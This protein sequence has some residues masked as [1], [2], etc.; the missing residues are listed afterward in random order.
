MHIQAIFALLDSLARWTS[1]GLM[2]KSRSDKTATDKRPD[3]H[4]IPSTTLLSALLEE[5]RRGQGTKNGDVESRGKAPASR[6]KAGHNMDY[7]QL[8]Q[9]VQSLV[10]GIPLKLLTFAA[11]R[12]KAYAR[13]LRYFELYARSKVINIVIRSRLA[14]NGPLM[15]R[16]MQ[17]YQDCTT[18]LIT[19]PILDSSELDLVMTIYSELEDPDAIQ[20]VQ[21][22]RQYGDHYLSPWHR[23]I[24]LEQTDDWL[25]ALLEYGLIGDNISTNVTVSAKI[26]YSNGVMDGPDSATWDSGAALFPSEGAVVHQAP[27]TLKATPW[28]M[29]RAKT[30]TRV[31]S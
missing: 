8:S 24:E 16:K 21:M 2:R 18:D 19:L 6:Q 31:R 4:S 25:G 23:I 10:D 28:I 29:T 26:D 5:V 1:R 11:L 7:L 9:A 12:I 30:C 14:H 22:L 27:T 15:L 13:A 3:G 20:G 17:E